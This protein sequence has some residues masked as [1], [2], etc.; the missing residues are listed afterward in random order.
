M[1][2][3]DE[4]C[5]GCALER[6]CHAS[7]KAIGGA[8]GETCDAG[9]RRK[10]SWLMFWIPLIILSVGLFVMVGLMAWDELLS[11]GVVIG[12]LAVYYMI[13]KSKLK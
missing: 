11:F 12:V 3:E 9:M 7:G 13:L 10:A 6:M 1:T 8:D 5:S 4:I 2:N